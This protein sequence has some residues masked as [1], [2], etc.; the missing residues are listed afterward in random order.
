MSYVKDIFEELKSLGRIYTMEELDGDYAIFTE[1]K[2]N[3]DRISTIL[4]MN[5]ISHEVEYKKNYDS[6]I[7]DFNIYRQVSV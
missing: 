3:K 2:E 7:I 5:E 1:N 4:K 6:F